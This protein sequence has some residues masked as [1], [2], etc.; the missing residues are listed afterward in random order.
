MHT[1]VTTSLSLLTIPIVHRLIPLSLGYEPRALSATHLVRLLGA[2]LTIHPSPHQLDIGSP[3]WLGCL[4]R[5]SNH[6]VECSGLAWQGLDAF[7]PL[8]YWTLHNIA[9]STLHQPR[10][11]LSTWD[12][13]SHLTRSHATLTCHITSP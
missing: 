6:L 13:R 9:R 5:T 3:R 7:P 2:P 10:T 12:L 8:D 4:G 1:F 11:L